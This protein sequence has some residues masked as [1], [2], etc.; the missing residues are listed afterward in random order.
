MNVC[1]EGTRAIAELL[2]HPDCHLTE[3]TLVDN[4]LI[5][6]GETP[7]GDREPVAVAPGRSSAT[8]VN[9]DGCVA[10]A[11]ALS[12]ASLRLRRLNLGGCGVTDQGATLLAAAMGLGLG[13]APDR[14]RPCPNLESVNLRSN[15]VG[16]RGTAALT[17]AVYAHGHV[18]ELQLAN[19]PRV[20]PEGLGALA[21]A[22]AKNKRRALVVEIRAAAGLE[23]AGREPG[24]AEMKDGGSGSGRCSLKRRGLNDTDAD[25]IAACLAAHPGLRGLDLSDNA[26]TER[27]MNALAGSLKGPFGCRSLCAI[28]VS[29]NPG[30]N[31]DAARRLAGAVAGNVLRAAG[32]GE[33][34]RSVSDR[35]LGDAG[36]A[37]VAA[38]ITS[39]PGTS[40]ALTAV[41]FHHN[42]IG[43]VGCQA[44]AVALGTLPKL[45][46]LAMYSN[47]IG[48]VGAAALAREM[49]SGNMRTLRVLDLG[50]NGIGDDGCEVI[51]NAIR[52]HPCLAELHLDH[53]GIGGRGGG[54]LEA[55]MSWTEGATSRGA[56]G[57]METDSLAS[58][59]GDKRH[60]STPVGIQRL[61]LHG[62]DAIPEEMLAR[63]NAIA[64]RNAAMAGEENERVPR[65]DA[66][67]LEAWEAAGARSTGAE[68][69]A[70]GQTGAV[71]RS[72]LMLEAGEGTRSRAFGDRVAASAAA[73]YRHRCPGHAANTRGAAVIAAIVAYDETADKRLAPGPM[74]RS[75][76]TIWG[77]LR[78]LSLG[79]GTKFMPPPVAEVAARAGTERWEA[80]V[81]D[82]HAEVLA[83]RALLRV[84]YREIQEITQEMTFRT[85]VDTE[86]GVNS[87]AQSSAIPWRLLQA[88][89]PGKGFE[90]RPGVSLHLYVSTAPC[91][92]AS[93]G[94]MS[95]RGGGKGSIRRQTEGGRD[96]GSGVG[97]VESAPNNEGTDVDDVPVEN[98][99]RGVDIAHAAAA[100]V[101][102]PGA[103][104]RA[105]CK[106]TAGE[107][108]EVPAPGCVW[109]SQGPRGLAAAVG[110]P[111]RSL[112]CSDKIARWQVL[113]LQGALLSHFVPT[114]MGFDTITIGRKFNP[115]RCRLGTCCRA[116]GW[117][118]PVPAPPPDCNNLGVRRNDPRIPPVPL[119]LSFPMPRHARALGTSVRVEG[120][121]AIGD[122]IA[123]KSRAD[124]GDGDESLCWARGEARAIRH[125]G[126]TG[127]AVGGARGRPAVSRA[128]LFEL[129]QQT[130][131]ALTTH[132]DMVALAPELAQ[133][134]CTTLALTGPGEKVGNQVIGRAAS[135]YEAA[136]LAA[137][138][139]AARRD[140]LLRSE[141]PQGTPLAQWL[142]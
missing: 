102:H 47:A 69:E 95:T 123:N 99:A 12:S 105:M 52:C 80:V 72:A 133:L 134:P 36:A 103:V 59:P 40:H 111:G 50:G 32:A 132:P 135:P 74:A 27:G 29:G 121:A 73:A 65:E 77:D 23:T 39:E 125:D 128:A 131:A 62:N 43:P 25:A 83:R 85:S 53:N 19:N 104:M 46:E 64:G 56:G 88:A 89:G 110:T 136:K 49:V 98:I 90:Q 130:L 58:P 60:T 18:T 75:S 127:G 122:G 113:G 16:E 142:L 14:P 37:E 26:I 42:D 71:P 140:M 87:G 119:S 116:L 67:V 86:G 11:K 129:F 100:A 115:E 120:A 38:W 48:G 70:A 41:G 97:V 139:Y 1:P 3:L 17:A 118:P 82:S 126:R 66:A 114:P 9:D 45:D 22:L 54:A 93:V 5:G 30:A 31:T 92:A 78:V 21:E 10:I 44:L 8:T 33:A 106:G 13:M 101:A 124:A 81:H 57:A 7:K 117:H 91:G 68:A 15:D 79:V 94:N 112:A 2:L 51:A 6:G 4:P 137:T 35:G 96:S 20:G 61:W 108:D 24:E 55:A 109:A 84:L 141:A 138:S 76:S 28:T 107:G 34:L 63:M